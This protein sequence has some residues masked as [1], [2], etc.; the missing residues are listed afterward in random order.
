M[1]RM[2]QRTEARQLLRACRDLPD[3]ARILEVGCGEG[4]R[5]E[6]LRR[7]GE[8]GWRLEGV[9]QRADSVRLA[10]R[11]GL[12]VRLGTITSV[13]L[14]EGSYDL[15]LLVM[16]LEQL[17]SPMEALARIRELL[18]PGGRIV[19]MTSDTATLD[20]SL[21]NGRHWGGY[22]F[23][24]SLQLF[25]QRSLAAALQK[26]GLEPVAVWHAT[27]P[28]N[29]IRSVRNVLA[30]LGAP[31]WLRGRFRDSSPG[32]LAIAATIEGLRGRMGRGA[33]L[34]LSA[35]R[36][37][38]WAPERSRWQSMVQYVPRVRRRSSKP[39]AIVGAGVAG[40]IA[41]D[42]LRRHG[43][44]VVV[45]EAGAQV[46]GLA[47]S[48]P[49]ADG[50][51]N[52]FGAHFITNRLAAAIGVGALCRDVHYYG[53]TVYL[54]GHTYSYPLGLAT[55]PR[56]ALSA[57][58]GLLRGARPEPSDAAECFRA[59][60]GD[61]LAAEVAIPLV[62]RWSGV[63]ATELAPSV[64]EKL[65]GGVPHVLA[66]KA[67]SRITHRAVAHGYC[68]EKPERASVWH[69]YPDG[70]VGVICEAIA[71]ELGD[72]IRLESPVER[73]IVDSNRVV[74]VRSRGHEEEVAAA[75]S[76]APVHVLPKIIEGTDMLAHLA[77]FRFR[78]MVLA[79]VRLRGRA[80]LPDVVL[81]FP[82]GTFP[83][84]RIT[85]APV[86]MPWLAPEG[87]THLSIDIGC[88]VSDPIWTM[89]EEEIGRLCLEHLTALIPDARS[90]YLGCRVM[91]TPIA[92][93]IY[94]KEYEAERQALAR[95]TGIDG[96]YSIGRNGEFG[97]L[98]M[99]DLYWRTLGQTRRLLAA[100]GHEG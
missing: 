70:G 17:D 44:P 84:F 48:F 24:R 36:P 26:S 29:L 14:P 76:T 54:S 88:E 92:Y 68:R 59:E 99:E 41:A 34:C 50:Y 43:V 27:S 52:D 100:L 1:H 94:L 72:S 32:A 21:L 95:S 79:N 97:H 63:R 13:K 37:A 81:W 10:R 46:A 39:V 5:L 56:F 89:D 91:R 23:P 8:K 12:R 60:Y 87:K 31:S 28:V 64:V 93:P 38:R 61:A 96:L 69:V 35:R 86:S 42:E 4:E 20:F 51:I 40:L 33:V 9:E 47:R 11:S 62:E 80:L 83:F 53:E 16:A 22:D 3:D 45:Y 7:F 65:A 73:I 49:D 6:L 66:L 58:A 98:L 77:R 78:P 2:L 30:D 74:A 67:A 19:V 55:V 85:E 75:L 18:R 71:A 82:E 90:R 25:D 57:L 15:V